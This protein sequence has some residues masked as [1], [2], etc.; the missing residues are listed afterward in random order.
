MYDVQI[1]YQHRYVNF[2]Y[3]QYSKLYY[4]YKSDF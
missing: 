2:L 1:S 3:F 4:V